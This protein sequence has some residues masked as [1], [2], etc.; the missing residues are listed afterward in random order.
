V[1]LSPKGRSVFAVA[2]A[3]ALD[4]APFREGECLESKFRDDSAAA[5]DVMPEPVD[6][7]VE[8]TPESTP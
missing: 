5:N 4:I 7:V 2:V 3:R 8:P 6:S 1:H